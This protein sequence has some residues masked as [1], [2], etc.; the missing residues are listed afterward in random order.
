MLSVY[1]RHYPPCQQQDPHFR[2]CQCPKWLQGT[3][4]P[5]QERV[6]KSANTRNWRIAE[7]NPM[8]LLAKPP[9]QKTMP[10]NYFT[11]KEFE[12][13]VQA[14][15]RY[16]YGGGH[17]CHYRGT[18]LRALV[19]L[20]RWSGL[21]IKDAVSLERTRLDEDGCLFLRRANQCACLRSVAAESCCCIAVAA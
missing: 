21:A 1:T 14:T 20:M 9:A 5:Y 16:G 8:D 11:R 7:R 4:W 3:L 2:R 12:T 10:T 13:I 15:C 17:D 19:L 18:R 6:R